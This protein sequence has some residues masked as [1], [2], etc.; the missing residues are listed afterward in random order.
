V[1]YD[2]LSAMAVFARVVDTGSFSKAAGALGLSKSAVSKQVSR[3]EDRLGARLL[4]RTTRQLSLT[5]AGT[6]FYAGCRQVVSEAEAAEA[7]V[8]HLAQAPRGRLHVNAPMSFGQKHVAPAL[9]ALLASYPELS[10]D[11]QLNDRTVDLVDE[12]F[13]VAVRIGQLS[14][15]TLIARR[16][17]PLRLAVAAAPDYL[18]RRGTPEHPT[19]LKQHDCLIYSYLA[20]GRTWSFKGPDG[21][22]RVGID[23]PIEA[24]NGDALCAAAL[25]G[26]GIVRLPTFICGDA[27]RAGT[28]R[29][30]LADWADPGDSGIYAVYP[31]SRNVSPKVR[32]FIDFLAAKFGAGPYWDRDLT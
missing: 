7:A 25:A 5:E 6:A 21:P 4:N 32:V 23:G 28:L 24:N 13:D 16:L 3:L 14:D 26:A 8:T 29:P 19:D 17:A 22:V 18:A 10:I 12:G 9:P 11:L 27:L 15:S 30:V 1:A 2:H 31:A 20:S